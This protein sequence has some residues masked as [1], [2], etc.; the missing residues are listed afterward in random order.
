M[1]IPRE[2][3]LDWEKAIEYGV[4][5]LRD[6]FDYAKIGTAVIGV[7]GGSD[8][9][10][11]AYLTAKAIGK[12]NVIG[13]MMPE[14]DVTPTEDIKDAEEVIES[15][16]VRKV[17]ADITGIVRHFSE[18]DP[19]LAK[20]GNRMAYANVK[21]RVRMTLLYKE[22]NKRNGL[23]VGTDDRSE[24]I[25]G[26][27]T[28]YG[29]GAV[30]LNAPSYL[31]KTQVRKLLEYI[32]EKEKMP[33]MKRIAEKKP[34]P[35]LWK[36]HSAEDELGID[37]KTLDVVMFYL[38]DSRASLG[39]VEIAKKLGISERAVHDIKKREL[40]NEHKR[41]MPPSPAASRRLFANL[42]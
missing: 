37:Y 4:S 8:S 17:Y 38:K 9:A 28:K 18:K 19:D 31:Y 29:D 42:K 21:A 35:R 26:Y 41:R 6:Y 12:E 5:W 11:T 32:S 30:D 36:G 39:D 14:D 7:S 2:L 3:E 1:E 20:P 40:A 15:L 33:V 13:V 25:M 10:L 22:A 27:F 24:H 16:G 23:V 34:S